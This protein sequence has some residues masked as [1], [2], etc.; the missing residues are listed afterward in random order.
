MEEVDVT[1]AVCPRPALV[2]RRRLREL[3][4]GDELLVTGD[5]PPAEQNLR[6]TCDKHGFE[7]ADGP[8]DHDGDTFQLRIRVTE[9]SE[10]EDPA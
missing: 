8:E 1:D 2:V 3:D 10:L 7:V 6:R 9:A 5:Y 4:P